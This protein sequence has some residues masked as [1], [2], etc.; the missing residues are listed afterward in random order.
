MLFAPWNG[1]AT[2]AEIVA[3]PEVP[4]F[5]A[6]TDG[7][8]HTIAE[9]FAAVLR[10]EGFDSRTI[11]LTR[12][13][14]HHV[15]WSR[16]RG[17]L[18]GASLHMGKHQRAVATFIRSHAI[19]LNAHPS[20]FFSVSLSAASKDANER[21]AAQKIADAFPSPLGWTPWRVV[22]VA[23]RIA[24]T[25]YGF[26]KRMLLKR[27]ARKEGAPTDTSRDYEFTDWN[28]VE[29]LARELAAVVRKGAAGS[30]SVSA[31]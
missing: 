2:H 10:D 9:R 4:V 19:D 7:Q 29:S 12:P 18:V 3:S 6:T 27:I 30:G 22:I 17:A 23:G 16:L 11:D 1:M 8:T 14:A 25:R 13:D 24:Y 28:Q 21:E 15:D 26:L 20:M 5:F 31:A